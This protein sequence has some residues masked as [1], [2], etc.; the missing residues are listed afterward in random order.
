M[1][2]T[3]TESIIYLKSFFSHARPYDCN[4]QIIIKLDS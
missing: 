3:N 1:F 4:M 2:K